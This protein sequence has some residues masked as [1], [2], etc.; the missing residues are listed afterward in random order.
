MGMSVS[1]V[2][3]CESVYRA[4][5]I[6]DEMGR[7]A[8]LAYYGYGPAT[9]YLLVVDGRDYDSKAICGVAYTLNHPDGSDPPSFSGGVTTTNT[10]A[11]VLENLGFRIVDKS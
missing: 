7:E 9:R 10:A 11:T 5:A 6:H 4:I 3:T 1:E 2:V 8:F